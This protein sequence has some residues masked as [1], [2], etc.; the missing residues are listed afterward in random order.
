MIKRRRAKE[1]DYIGPLKG[2]PK[3]FH[4][5]FLLITF[6]LRKPLWTLLILLVMFLLPTFRGVKPTEVHTWY[7]QKLKHSS[8]AISTTVTDKAK[9]LSTNLPQ[10]LPAQEPATVAPVKVV[11]MPAKKSSRT[12]FERAK[13]APVV[14]PEAVQTAAAEPAADTLVAAETITPRKDL[15]LKYLD[16]PKTISGQVIV[17]SANVLMIGKSE[18]FLY[19]IY[20]E[21]A[22]A[23]GKAAVEYLQEATSGQTVSCQVNAYTYQ[24]VATAICHVGATNLNRE[25][26]NRGFSK[27]VALD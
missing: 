19:G 22:S 18:M 27:N 14:V 26:V 7:W 2:W 13:S 15:Q 16:Q 20:A 5:L 4:R 21:P 10:V 17:I 3:F 9:D 24:G 6:P 8:A 11:E 1:D 23:N 25:L 12:V